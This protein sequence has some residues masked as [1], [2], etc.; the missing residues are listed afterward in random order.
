MCHP[1]PVALEDSEKSA[2]RGRG[3]PTIELCLRDN[4]G[5]RSGK[6]ECELHGSDAFSGSGRGEGSMKQRQQS[7]EPFGTALCSLHAGADLAS[8]GLSWAV[9]PSPSTLHN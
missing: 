2:S 5:H 6:Q 9:A 3:G 4:F 7:A 8:Q 1:I